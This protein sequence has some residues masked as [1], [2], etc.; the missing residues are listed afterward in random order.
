MMLYSIVP[1]AVVERKCLAGSFTNAKI[2]HLHWK[3]IKGPL[4]TLWMAVMRVDLT[5][6]FSQNIVDFPRS[7]RKIFPSHQHDLDTEKGL[8]GRRERLML[9]RVHVEQLLLHFSY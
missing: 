1:K 8:L 6:S 2:L 4:D 5:S 3:Q 9:L 7:S